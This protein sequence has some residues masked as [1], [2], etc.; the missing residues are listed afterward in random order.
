MLYSRKQSFFISLYAFECSLI[1]EQSKVPQDH[2][3][4]YA[5]NK[6]AMYAVDEDGNYGIV[7]SSGWDVEEAVTK[8][9]LH[10]LR[11]LADEAFVKV[12][13]GEYSE[14]FFHMYDR[15]MDLQV[16]SETT[17]LFK[18][19]IKRHFKPG[20]FRKLSAKLKQRYCDAMGLS[21]QELC[22]LPERNL[23]W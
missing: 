3:S 15:R 12:K 19:R 9:A 18:F 14:L 23:K 21:E 16:L 10:E 4:T 5:N 22:S 17:G 11:S 20:V 13:K 7:A 1:M 2:I 6:K 8:Q